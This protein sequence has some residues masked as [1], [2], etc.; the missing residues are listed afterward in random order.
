VFWEAHY[1]LGGELDSAN[2][3]VEARAEF[4]E[5]VRL[6]PG[7]ARAHFNYGVLLAKQGQLDEAQRE[8]VASR[9]VCK[10]WERVLGPMLVHTIKDAE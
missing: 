6:Q 5:A 3:L 7:N 10:S 8:L 2:Q 4:A 9:V 1:D